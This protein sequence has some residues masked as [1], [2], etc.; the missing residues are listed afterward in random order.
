MRGDSLSGTSSY[1]T[2][3]GT[4]PSD[5]WNRLATSLRE[6]GGEERL[7]P[8]RQLGGAHVG[9]LGNTDVFEKK[10]CHLCRGSGALR[11]YYRDNKVFQ[12]QFM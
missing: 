4:V 7:T 6:Q 11:S 8:K 12:I 9:W 2:L 10:L 5:E 1:T 3:E